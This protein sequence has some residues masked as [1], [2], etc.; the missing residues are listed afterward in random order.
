MSSSI[1]NFLSVTQW[2]KNDVEIFSFLICSFLNVILFF[3][4]L[5]LTYADIS[6]FNFLNSWVAKDKIKG[7]PAELENFPLLR[8]LYER[9]RDIPAVKKR[10]E[11][12]PDTML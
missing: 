11:T 5:Q 7:Y 1:L 6:F 4:I 10:L 8:G 12:R 2:F 3:F 9:V